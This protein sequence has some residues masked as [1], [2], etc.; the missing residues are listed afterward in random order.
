MKKNNLELLVKAIEVTEESLT[1]KSNI[2]F[3]EELINDLLCKKNVSF[4]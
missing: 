2:I 4:K 3:T 1:L